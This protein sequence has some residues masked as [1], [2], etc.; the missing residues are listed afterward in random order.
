[1]DDP[2]AE[3]NKTTIESQGSVAKEGDPK[4]PRQLYELKIK[5]TQRGRLC[6]YGIYKRTLRAPTK[7]NALVL[8]SVD[9]GGKNTQDKDQIRI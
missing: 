7:E 4:A 2:R 6:L 8:R 1:M 9:S 5:S 3:G